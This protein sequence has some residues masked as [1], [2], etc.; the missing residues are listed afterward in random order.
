MDF[1]EL[2]PQIVAIAEAAGNAIL[3][4]YHTADFGVEA[5]GDSSPL[6]LADKAANTVICN[7]LE[8]LSAYSFPIIS[9]ENKAV[10]YAERAQYEYYW[11]V[12]PLDGTKEF[13]KRNGEFT[14]N[15]ALICRD[16]V[17]FGVV[18]TPCAAETAWA[19]KGAGA[20]LCKDGTETPLAAA[21]YRNTDE[22][23]RIFC[24]RSHLNPETEAFIAQ[25]K[26]PISVSKGSSLKF[27]LIAAGEAHVYPRLAPTMEWDTAAAQIIV[28]EAG[29]RVWNYET[30][31]ALRYNKENLLNPYFVVE[32][33]VVV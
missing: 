15:I 23:L 5:K 12:D 6:T 14:V 17:V 16:T 25:Y 9:E 11:L 2:A 10:P 27:L 31:Q 24:S 1:K 32:G 28:E 3:S 26:D 4:I 8:Q 7:A 33:S 19:G 22:Q 13:I 18:H 21:T 30:K 29:G 20:W